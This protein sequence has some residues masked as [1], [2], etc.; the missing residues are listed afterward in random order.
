MDSSTFVSIL[1]SLPLPIPLP[2]D[3]ETT[4]LLL[5]DNSFPR[6]SNPKE[7]SKDTHYWRTVTAWKSERKG[8]VHDFSKE[9]CTHGISKS[10]LFPIDTTM[11]RRLEYTSRLVR[12]SS[13]IRLRTSPAI[14]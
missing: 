8:P 12:V 11:P 7:L 10:K 4:I 5:T 6:T 14:P 3:C 9:F 1:T 2:K 13:L